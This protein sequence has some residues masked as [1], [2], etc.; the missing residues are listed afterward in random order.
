MPVKTF[1]L[2][3]YGVD[4]LN[5]VSRPDAEPGPGEVLLDVRAISLNYRDL[6]TIEGRYARGLD[7]PAVLV[8]DCAGTILETGPGVDRVKPGDRVM[9]HFMP[10]WVDGPFREEYGRT[11]L[12]WPGPGV[13][14][15]RVVLPEGGVL[16]L[17]EGYSFA[18][19][20]TLPI[21]A[22]TA[23]SSL[24]TSFPLEGKTVA[25]LGTGGVSI[26]GLQI[27]KAMGARVIVT[28]KSDAKL[29][30]AAELGADLGVN[31]A[32]EPDW[33]RPIR[34]FTDGLGADLILEAGG[35]ATLPRSI[36]ATRAGGVIALF[37]V[38]TGGAGEIETR[39]LLARRIS[40]A[41]IFVDSRRRFED[42]SAFLEKE[43]IRPVI[44][45]EFPFERLPDALR[46]MQ[47][48]EHFGKIVVHG[49]TA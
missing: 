43:S 1:E 36:K 27:A 2:T 48:A 23:W 44:G 32:D 42:L 38:L 18:E 3:D 45:A 25:V 47:A 31:Y 39:A 17:P 20:A 21:A 11:T 12:G 46:M 24:A 5:L 33:H 14:A 7:L 10:D 49:P 4:N 41:G 28:S 8:A 37:G 6:S 29:A 16:P 30:R 35:S 15:E 26:F 34:A 13:A 9:S 19:A 40:I 22:L